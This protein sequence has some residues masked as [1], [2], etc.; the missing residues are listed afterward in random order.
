VAD[1]KD[2]KFWFVTG[3]QFLYGPE[4]LTQVEED[5]KKLINKL[6]ESGKLPYPIEFKTVGVTA[7]NITKT[8]MEAN[9]DDSVAGIITWAHTFSPAKNW[10]RGT[11]LLNKPLMHLATQM[12]NTIPYDTI[13]FDYMNLNQSAHGDREYAFINAR[14]RLNNKIIFGHWADDDIQTQIGKW[15]DVAVAYNESFKIKIVTFADKM[16]NVAVTDGDK[17]EAQIKL[18]WTVD[19]WGVGDLVAYVNA[20]NDDDI[21]QLYEDLQEKYD[22]I[23]GKNTPEK[24]EHNV[25]YQLR[26]YI[27]LKKFMTDKGYSGFT[28]NFEDLVGLEQLPG[29]AVQLLMAD[30]YGFA[31]EGDW[32]TAA[33][34]RL[35]KI[36]S[37]NQAT[38]F[39]E[40]YKFDQIERAHVRTPDPRTSTKPNT[41]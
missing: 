11:Q 41:A 29:L 28:T 31:G 27:A 37:H 38:A 6:N 24:F 8:M 21:D 39:K 2:Y 32:K 20:V 26:E 10:I 25:K 5:S 15:M 34:T 36:V 23:E 12:L 30:G 4:V 33:L 9:Y 1:I 19:Y 14:L 16:R 40:D 13:D 18:G 7:E 22:F 35:L 17:I 3:S